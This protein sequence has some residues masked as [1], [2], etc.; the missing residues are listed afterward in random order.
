VSATGVARAAPGHRSEPVPDP[1]ARVRVTYAVSRWGA[2]TETFVRREAA[3]VRDTG[4]AVTALSIKPAVPDATGIDVVHLGAVTVARQALRTVRRA[5]GPSWSVL[6]DV[7]RGAR[8][9]TLA[10]RITAAVV[11]LAWAQQPAATA[12]LVHTH[13]GWVAATATWAAARVTGR[14]YSVVVH[15]FELHDRA[16]LDRFTGVPLREAQQ[17]FTISDRDRVLVAQRWG[18]SAD[19]LRM[20][21]DDAWLEAPAVPLADREPWTIVAVGSLVPKKGHAV[22]VDALA[23]AAHPWRL[24]IVGE[25]PERAVLEARIAA[26]DLG[27]R[28]RLLGSC[29]EAEARDRVGRAALVALA[30]AIAPDGDRDGIP[31]ALM[32]AMALGTPVVSTRVGG[33]PELVEHAGILVEPDDPAALAAALDSLADPALRDSVGA[34]GRSVVAGGFRSA[35][36]AA[37]VVRLAEAS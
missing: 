15:A 19:V 25:G 10:A 34:R 5:P 9:R 4:V 3:A 6:R 26:R 18:I 20:G 8:P 14:P 35:D 36:Q 16:V 24:D 21:V 33:I 23:R 28:V 32:E 17:V 2:P 29:S 1:T 31:V 12:D 11:G 13:F 37:R 7:V 30:C 22:L 27:D